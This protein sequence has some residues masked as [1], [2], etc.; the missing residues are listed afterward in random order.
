M[1]LIRAI[2]LLLSLEDNSWDSKDY[3]SDLDDDDAD[4]N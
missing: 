2:V 1:N 3:P 4:D